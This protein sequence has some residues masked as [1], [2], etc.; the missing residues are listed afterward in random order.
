MTM[1][2][3]SPPSTRAI[4]NILLSSKWGFSG[5]AHLAVLTELQRRGVLA[6]DGKQI[7]LLDAPLPVFSGESTYDDAGRHWPR[8]MPPTHRQAHPLRCL[9]WGVAALAKELPGIPA[10]VV[11]SEFGRRAGMVRRPTPRVRDMQAV[12]R[13]ANSLSA[14]SA[15]AA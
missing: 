6:T 11:P 13:W 9:P 14:D 7:F 2:N 15:R 4:A 10:G 5:D 1:T 12:W 8:T 3:A